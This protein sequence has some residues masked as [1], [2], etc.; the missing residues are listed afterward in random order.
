MPAAAIRHR[1]TGG[2]GTGKTTLV[3]NLFAELDSDEVV[4][5]Q[6]VTS[7]LEADDMLTMV[8]AA[9]GLA[10]EAGPAACTC[11]GW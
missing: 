8:V 7:Q 11:R 10:Y 9:F 3:R 2:I 6:L 4:A 1:H 5:A